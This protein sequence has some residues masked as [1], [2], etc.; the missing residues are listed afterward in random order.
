MEKLSLCGFRQTRVA[1]LTLLTH[2]P[3]SPT[4]HCALC[5]GHSTCHFWQ[6]S[7][8][9]LVCVGGILAAP[10]CCHLGSQQEENE[11]KMSRKTAL[12]RTLNG[13]LSSPLALGFNSSI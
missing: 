4:C 2:L 7:C 6:V 12:L 9:V 8:L 13:S 11:I 5:T 3:V 10:T 1:R